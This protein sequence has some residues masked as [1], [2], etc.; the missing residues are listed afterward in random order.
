[1][2]MPL[3]ISVGTNCAYFFGLA[4]V[5]HSIG[6]NGHAEP[7]LDHIMTAAMLITFMLFG[8]I[9]ESRAKVQTA[10]AIKHLLKCQPRSAVLV[11]GGGEGGEGCEREIPVDLLHKGDIVKVH[12]RKSSTRHFRITY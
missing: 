6:T 8:K 11:T 2:G 5:L 4:T 3:L 9:M 7:A 10:F 12:H 1:M